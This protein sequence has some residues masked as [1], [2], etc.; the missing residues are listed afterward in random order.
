MA[1]DRMAMED[2]SRDEAVAR[3]RGPSGSMVGFFSQLRVPWY[4]ILSIICSID[5]AEH[6]KSMARKSQNDDI[7]LACRG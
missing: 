1:V 5:G 4:S 3:L 7:N 6:M 2:M